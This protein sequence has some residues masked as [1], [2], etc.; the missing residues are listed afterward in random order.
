MERRHVV[1]LTPSNDSES[2]RNRRLY[3]PDVYEADIR[4]LFRGKV[5][6]RS[7]AENALASLAYTDI[8]KALLVD[9]WILELREEEERAAAFS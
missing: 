1:D 3:Y 7:E 9:K 5:I 4:N 6:D 2:L 8:D